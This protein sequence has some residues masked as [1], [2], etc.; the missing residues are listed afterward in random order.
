MASDA[1][2]DA[3]AQ[4]MLDELERQPERRR[5]LYQ[6][7][8]TARIIKNFGTEFT[9]TNKNGNPAIKKTVLDAFYTLHGGTVRWEP[10]GRYWRKKQPGDPPG[11]QA[12]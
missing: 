8:A 2:P 11:R 1:T 6:I 5:E 4:W 7:D 9:Y 10:R 3:V 12:Q